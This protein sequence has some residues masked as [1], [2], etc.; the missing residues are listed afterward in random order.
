MAH[1]KTDPPACLLLPMRG[2][3]GVLTP[4][5]DRDERLGMRRQSQ[6][7]ALRKSVGGAGMAAGGGAGAGGRG[8][9]SAED[10][11]TLYDRV[12]KLA[13]ENK[14]NKNN[15]WDIDVIYHMPSIIKGE[16]AAGAQHFNFQRASCGLAAG[17]DI[18]SK[19]VDSVY[20]TCKETLFGFQGVRAADLED[21][22][23]D[24]REG[25][26]GSDQGDAAGGEGGEGE[27]GGA[28]KRKPGATGYLDPNGTLTDA[29]S[30]RAKDQFI[31]SAVRHSRSG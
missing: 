22:E 17:V 28:R 25:G 23:D 3:S 12:I 16:H 9:M 30:L 1:L 8:G 11:R 29:D 7:K 14:I 26:G 21:G 27:G 19:R 6:A 13:A 2:Q 5:N 18:Y 4:N 24:A 15:A 10:L 20:E 31:S